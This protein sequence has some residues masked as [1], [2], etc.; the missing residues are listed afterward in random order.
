LAEGRAGLDVPPFTSPAFGCRVAGL[1][2]LA[3]RP[4][5]TNIQA[6]SLN[7]TDDEIQG[8]APPLI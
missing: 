7:L 6:M 8:Q 1:F 3:D 5:F 4:I 2:W